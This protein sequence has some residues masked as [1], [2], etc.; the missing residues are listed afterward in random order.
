M[1]GGHSLISTRRIQG[2][3]HQWALNCH[4]VDAPVLGA[5]LWLVTISQNWKLSGRE[6]LEWLS[7]PY[8]DEWN[9]D[10]KN[11]AMNHLFLG[12]GRSWVTPFTPNLTLV[13]DCVL[14][15]FLRCLWTDGPHWGDQWMKVLRVNR[16]F[17]RSYQW[18]FLPFLSSSLLP[19]S[20][21]HPFPFPSS[22]PLPP[23]S[24][25]FVITSVGRC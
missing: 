5:S 4:P 13:N 14:A 18:L 17:K 2:N 23:L 11:V 22:L 7:S 25:V 19:V 21:F 24:L 3:C 8:S 15:L 1:R 16:N 20:S 12:V 9:L 10:N 6:S